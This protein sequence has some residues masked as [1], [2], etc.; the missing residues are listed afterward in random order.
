MSHA[1]R[2]A[3][4]AGQRLLTATVSDETPVSQAIVET[5]ATIEG[6][7]A[8]DYSG[9]LY[10]SIDPE[11]L[12]DLY[13]SNTRGTPPRIVFTFDGYEVVVAD[14]CITVREQANARSP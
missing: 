9:Q 8:T 5:V 12:D 7:E 4:D 1:I 11:A 6:T 10:D 3:G 13:A 2:H 14:E